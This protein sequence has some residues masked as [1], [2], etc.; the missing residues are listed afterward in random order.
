MKFEYDPLKSATNKVKHGIDF[1]EAQAL[2][3]DAKSVI[4]DL[5]Q[6]HEE[7]RSIV[8]GILRKRVWTAIVTM[9]G[10]AVRII[11]MRRAR[12][13]EVAVYVAYAHQ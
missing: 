9:R 12:E 5:P 3:Q 1:D 6:S 10:D 11:S 4:I 13:K 8:M 2:W 7:P